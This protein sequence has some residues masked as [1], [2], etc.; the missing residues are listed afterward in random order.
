MRKNYRLTISYD[1]TRYQGWQKQKKTSDTIQGK[2]EEVLKRMQPLYGNRGGEEAEAGLVSEDSVRPDEIQVIGAGRTDA[3]VHAKAMTANVFLDI[4]ID[5]EGLKDYLNRY[6]PDDISVDAVKIASDRF[7]SRFQA[8]A[9]TYCY[10]LYC[11]DAKPVFDRKYVTILEHRPNVERMRRAADDLLGNHD[12]KAF[13]G[14]PKMKKST[15]RRIDAVEITEEGDYI[16]IYYR[17]NAFLQNMVRIMTGTLLE[18]GFGRMPADAIPGILASLDRTQ[19]G[20]TAPAK[21]LCMME[22]HYD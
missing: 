20:P 21:G 22:V 15:W 10:S 16:R 18:I 4:T 13:C 9:K 3:G 8:L 1:G 2:L 14:N 7:H 5:E 11:G 12:F 6:L 17:G 19:A